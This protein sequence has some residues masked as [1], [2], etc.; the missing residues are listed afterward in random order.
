[1]HESSTA[2]GHYGLDSNANQ[3]S[4]YTYGRNQS[5]TSIKP[6]GALRL[7]KNY[8]TENGGIAPGEDY[9]MSS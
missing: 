2:G 4:T 3:H 9:T 8:P 7:S 6:D 5:S 1:M